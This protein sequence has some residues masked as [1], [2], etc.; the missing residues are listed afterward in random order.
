MNSFELNDD[1]DSKTPLRSQPR[2][3]IFDPRFSTAL[4]PFVFALADFFKHGK[5]GLF[6]VGDGQRLEFVRRIEGGNDLAHRLFA[7]RTMRQRLGRKRSAQRELAAADLAVA[8]AQFVFVKR[9]ELISN[10][11]C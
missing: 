3:S 7:R 6:R 8:F 5:P 9:H 10:L 2:L 1:L 11:D 4:L